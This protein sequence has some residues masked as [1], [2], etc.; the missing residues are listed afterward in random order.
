MSVTIKDIAKVCN[1]SH[2]TVSRVLN[3]KCARQTPRTEQIISTA[4]ALG[5][6]PNTLAQQLVKRSSNMVGLMIPDIANP[7]YS[8]ITKCVEDAAACA[9]YRVFLCN[10]D[11]DVRKEQM[12]RD[13]LLES[14]VAGI[15]VMPVCDESHVMFRGLPVP[16]VLLGSR[17]L[18]PELSYVVMDNERAAHMAAEYFIG[19][20]RRRLC[21]IARPVENYT[22]SDR[23]KGFLAATREAGIAAKDVAI[24]RSKGHA[25]KG[26]YRATK[27]LIEQNKTP[28]AIL[29]FNDFIALGAIQAVEEAGL[30]VGEDVA[31]MGFDD[32]LFSSLPKINLTTIT[33][34]NE[35]LGKAAILPILQQTRDDL[36][37][38]GQVK[39]L[40]PHM[41]LRA[42]CGENIAR[43]RLS[44]QA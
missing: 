40:Q 25:L 11:W 1:V 21:Y 2:S 34:S 12:Y 24:T 7:H 26:G 29:A 8:E 30:T 14:Q 41:V 39:I 32:I 9:G 17:T 15:I 22:S 27:Q 38:K 13:S 6:K 37:A 43:K 18:E 44:I 4:K 16:V 31:V 5:Y 33:P 28:D 42:T 20:G 35:E 3:N 10:T 36:P 19:L 23:E